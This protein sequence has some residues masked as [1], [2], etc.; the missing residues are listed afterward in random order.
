MFLSEEMAEL[1]EETATKRHHFEI[2]D[3]DGK[4]LK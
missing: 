3:I 2:P 1:W 4:V